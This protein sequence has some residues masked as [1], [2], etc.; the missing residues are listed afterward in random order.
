MV[1]F[2]KQTGSCTWT[3][4]ALTGLVPVTRCPGVIFPTDTMDDLDWFVNFYTFCVKLNILILLRLSTRDK[5]DGL[6]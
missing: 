5:T 3:L 6:Q 1:E 2:P 4:P